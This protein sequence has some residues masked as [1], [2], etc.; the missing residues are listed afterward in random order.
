MT[1]L[2]R[3]D[4]VYMNTSESN[5]SDEMLNHRGKDDDRCHV[6]LAAKSAEQHTGARVTVLISEELSALFARTF[7]LYNPRRPLTAAR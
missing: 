2:L 7:H 6:G 3:L 1:A 5:V 4:M